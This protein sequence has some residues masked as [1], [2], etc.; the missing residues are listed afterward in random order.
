MAE[1]VQDGQQPKYTTGDVFSSSSIKYICS[2]FRPKSAS[3][4]ASKVAFFRRP[5]SFRLN[6]K[7]RDKELH[8][9]DNKLM[10]NSKNWIIW[11][12]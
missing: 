11:I 2:K 5:K 4:K 7:Q 1:P 3:R 12:P 6:F 8:N 10:L 9:L